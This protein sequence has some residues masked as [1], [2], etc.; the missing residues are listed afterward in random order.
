MYHLY[1]QLYIV[2]IYLEIHQNAFNFAT[3]AIHTF[4]HGS[5][6]TFCC[7]QT[8]SAVFLKLRNDSEGNI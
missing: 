1:R 2:I 6:Q 7:G 3:E 8:T 4:F 5:R